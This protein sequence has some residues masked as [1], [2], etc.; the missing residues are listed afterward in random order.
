M[1][2]LPVTLSS[3]SS[4]ISDTWKLHSRAGANVDV[5]P[6]Y[7]GT[8]SHTYLLAMSPSQSTSVSSAWT[9]KRGTNNNTHV[10]GLWN[11]REFGTFGRVSSTERLLQKQRLLLLLL[12][13]ACLW[14]CIKFYLMEEER[15]CC[16]DALFPLQHSYWFPLLFPTS[17]FLSLF[18]IW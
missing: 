3:Q 16:H 12:L 1:H 8:T 14:N 15:W 17:K 2:G 5:D 4:T 6:D 7:L 10:M 18:R 11:Y 9:L 13:G